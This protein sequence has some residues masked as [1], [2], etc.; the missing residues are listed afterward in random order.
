MI[1]LS[2][3][4]SRA[5][6]EGW[7]D[8]IKSE[9]DER[10]VLEGCKFDIDAARHVCNFFERY[11]RVTI[12]EDRPF[13]L[14]D[15][16]KFDILM[17]LYGWKRPDGR[18]RYTK[19]DVFVAKKNGKS[20]ICGGLVLYALLTGGSRAQ[21]FGV[22]HSREQAA[23]IY[24]EAASMARNAPQITSML[25]PLDSKKRIVYPET[26]SFYQA[27]AGENGSRSAEGI[28]PSLIVMDEIHVQRSRELYDALTY[29][30]IA[31]Q[32]GLMLS[33]STVG[34]ADQTTIWWEQYTYA[35]GILSGD[36][37]DWSRFAYIA[38]AD[39]EC[40]T[41]PE[42]RMDPR[43][44]EKANPSLGVTV[45]PEKVRDAVVEAENSPAKMNNLLRYIF[46]IPT[47]QVDKVVPVELWKK[48]ETVLPNLKGRRCYGGLDMASH[49]DISAFVL[50]FP[51][52]DGE[53][54][55][56]LCWLWCPEEKVRQR[57]AKQQAFYRVWV[58]DGDLLETEGNRIDPAPIEA[59]IRQ[60]FDDY[61]LEEVGFDPWN[62]DSVVNPLVNEGYAVVQVPQ[63]LVGM[64]SGTQGILD[65]IAEEKIWHDGNKVMT[66]CLSN[67]AA[68]TK[69]D[70]IKFDKDKSADKIDGAVALAIAKGRHLDGK[71]QPK[72][73]LF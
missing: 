12:G 62:A 72:P 54:A 5:K 32:D 51:A 42:M 7:F 47:A 28:N 2:E 21:V 57:E 9:S 60:A 61:Q 10:A 55:Y 71:E 1:R 14:L 15:W 24:D 16:Q 65:E 11:L 64:S 25:R 30:S 40:K 52:E 26:S 45:L 29:A 3:A 67:C 33:V 73:Q 70:A 22:A 35:K 50:Y 6:A 8:W 44:W 63:T 20:T 56:V 37:T 23:I 48:C 41:S 46:N 34:V 19:G 59:T 27:L 4:L 53:K 13:K 69:A 36:I 43:Q 39:E 49:E 38:Q 18:R 17:P 58:D 31:R 68:N 66:W